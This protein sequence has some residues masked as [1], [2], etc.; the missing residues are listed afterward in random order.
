MPPKKQKTEMQKLREKLKNKQQ[1]KGNLLQQIP[2]PQKSRK[3]VF[4][5]TR[6]NIIKNIQEDE[7]INTFFNTMVNL[8]DDKIVPA[9]INF[10]TDPTGAWDRKAYFQKFINI[11]PKKYYK[12]FAKE[13]IEQNTLT[14]TEFWDEYTSRPSIAVDIRKKYEQ[15][16]L[17]HVEQ[18]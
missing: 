10:A 11:L 15:K 16:S 9:V 4:Q 8:P 3:K 2:N 7:K 13:F 6:Q 17:L 1:Q 12:S 5:D 18:N 14:R